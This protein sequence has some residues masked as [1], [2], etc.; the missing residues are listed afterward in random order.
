MVN[1]LIV[2]FFFA[3][4]GKKKIKIIFCFLLALYFLSL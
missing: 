1:I 4:L 3:K 2:F